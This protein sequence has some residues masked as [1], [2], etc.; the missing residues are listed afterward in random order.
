LS[1]NLDLFLL[2][3]CRQSFYLSVYQ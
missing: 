3:F 2:P 1:K